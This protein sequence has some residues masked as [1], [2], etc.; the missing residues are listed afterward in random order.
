MYRFCLVVA[1]LVFSNTVRAEW[2]EV[3]H[4]EIQTTYA[5]TKVE[6]TSSTKAKILLL[7]DY[8]NA[9]TY[10][11]RTFLSV[12]SQN[13]FN[14]KDAQWQMLSYALYA[15]HKGT[16]DVI[17]SNATPTKLKAVMTDTLDETLMKMACA[18]K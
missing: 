14:C 6:R 2:L 10:D 13:E 18:K 11:D 4:S 9:V 1:L 3:E 8:K 12:L 17:Y 5:D 16:G 7:S 15:G